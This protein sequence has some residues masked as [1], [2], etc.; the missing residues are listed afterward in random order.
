MPLTA[1]HTLHHMPGGPSHGV[2]IDLDPQQGFTLLFAQQVKVSLFCYRF[3]SP[4]ACTLPVWKPRLD[5][6]ACPLNVYPATS[7]RYEVS[8]NS[9][10]A[11]CIA[12]LDGWT[13]RLVLSVSRLSVRATDGGKSRL[14]LRLPFD[15]GCPTRYGQADRSYPDPGTQHSVY[16]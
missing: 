3:S 7:R 10:C 11:T 16:V 8:V 2:W 6:G 4:D 12:F 9:P 15:P 5:S 14:Q 13:Q 1:P